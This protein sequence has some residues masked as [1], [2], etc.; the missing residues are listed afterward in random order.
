LE[1]VA[2]ELESRRLWNLWIAIEFKSWY[3]HMFLH[4]YKR[5]GIASLSSNLCAE[6]IKRIFQYL[7]KFLIL[8]QRGKPVVSFCPR[9]SAA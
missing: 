9:E 7:L 3:W 5:E 1:D 2:G 6:G 8:V 4:K